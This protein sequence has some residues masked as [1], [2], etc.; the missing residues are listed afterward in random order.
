MVSVEEISFTY[1]KKGIIAPLNVLWT[2]YFIRGNDEK[3]EKIW[4]EYVKNSPRIMFQKVIQTIRENN[5]VD[6]AKKLVEQ[7]GNSPVT[8]GALG[9][10][11][12]CLLDVLTT[13]N[14]HEEAIA[15]FERAVQDVTIDN[16]NRTA[17]LRVKDCYEQQG[18][19]FTSSIPSKKKNNIPQ[20]DLL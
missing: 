20:D 6:L 13:L 16:L 1:A 9:N 15:Y 12:S 7:L 10:A 19:P 14:K 8:T 18:K 4:N 11:Y 17:V 2:H 3:A 5:D